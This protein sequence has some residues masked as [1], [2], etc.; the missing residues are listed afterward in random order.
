MSLVS[1]AVMEAPAKERYSFSKLSSWWVCPYGWK[2]RYIDHQPGIGNAF[3]S[4]G[5]F[6]HSIMERYANGEVDIWDLPRIYEWEFDTAV[7]EKFPYNQYVV[8][9]DSYYKQGLEFLKAFQGYDDYKIL[10]VEQNFDTD[11]DDWVFNGIID[12]ILEDKNGKLIIRDYKSKAS[13]KNEAEKREYARQLYLYSTYVY[14]KFG[15][16]PDE[17][18]FLMFRKNDLVQIPFNKNDFNESIKWAKDTVKTI[19]EAFDYP[20]RCEDF[21]AANLCN[22]REYCELRGRRIE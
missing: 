14:N 22:H 11:I 12:L 6:V 15:R 4:Y 7:P 1:D 9:R 8:L 18:Q 20:P 16:F 2:L 10:G 19:R 21:Y 3:S 5:T 13:F 17:L